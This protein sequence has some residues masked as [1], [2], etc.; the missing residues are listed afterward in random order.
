VT[1]KNL[2]RKEKMKPKTKS[3]SFCQGMLVSFTYSGGR[4]PNTIKRVCIESQND[5]T[6]T[7]LD[8]DIMEY[9]TY[10]IDRMSR[11]LQHGWYPKYLISKKVYDR[12]GFKYNLSPSDIQEIMETEESIK[13]MNNE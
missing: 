5:K 2:K 8:I 4:T 7:G 1:Q 10:R 12:I 9:R 6:I 13:S 11:I 3:C